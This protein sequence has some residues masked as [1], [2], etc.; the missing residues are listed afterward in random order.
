MGQGFE[1]PVQD[2]GREDSRY[3]AS[4]SAAHNKSTCFCVF[5][6]NMPLWIV[7]KRCREPTPMHVLRPACKACIVSKMCNGRRDV[8]GFDTME[9]ARDDVPTRVRTKVARRFLLSAKRHCSRY[10]GIVG[11]I[12]HLSARLVDAELCSATSLAF[13]SSPPFSRLAPSSGAG[14][15]SSG[16]GHLLATP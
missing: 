5:A 6:M 12:G 7:E 3:G 13:S 1:V 2:C 9:S 10:G 16:A 11:A 4:S 8:S 15:P 14:R